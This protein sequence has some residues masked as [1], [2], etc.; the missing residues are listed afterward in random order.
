[1]SMDQVGDLLFENS[2]M[3]L[4]AYLHEEERYTDFRLIYK[5]ASDVPHTG[6]F[7]LGFVSPKV[8]PSWWLGN[9]MSM[10]A[11]SLA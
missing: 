1:M 5:H 2:N 3:E 4:S 11:G 10:W 6:S 8:D 7:G 9:G